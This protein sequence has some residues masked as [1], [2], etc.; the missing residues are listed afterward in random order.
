MHCRVFVLTVVFGSVTMKKMKSWYIG[1]V[2]G[3]TI[4]THGFPV[5]ALCTSDSNKNDAT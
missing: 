4:D 3:A 2:I 1:P 5:T